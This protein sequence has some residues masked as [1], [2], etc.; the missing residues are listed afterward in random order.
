M[1]PVAHA[2]SM[3]VC[4][5]ALLAVPP[6]AALAQAPAGQQAQ[7][8]R[9]NYN[10]PAGPLVPALR[11][12]ASAANLPLT[13][14]AD[15]TEGKRTAG[16]RGQFTQQEALAALLGGTGLQAVR[17]D[18]GGYVLRSQPAPA[19]P[20]PAADARTLPTVRVTAEAERETATGPLLGYAARIS[21][22]AT[23]T[24]TPLIEVPQSI[25]VIGRAEM[26][27]RGAQD[28]MDAVRYTPGV[29]TSTYGP[30]NRSWEYILLRG[31]EAGVTGIYRDGLGQPGFLPTYYLT[32]PY[33]L[34][35]VEVLRGPASMVFGKADAGG[36][37]NRVSKEPGE[38][39][40]EIEVQY[41][42]FQRKQLAFDLGDKIGG[43]TDLSYR[44]IGV[45]L[46]GNDQDRYPDGRKLNHTRSYIAPSVRWQPNASTSLTVFGEYLR[47]NTAEDPYYFA[48]NY[49]QYPI[50][51]G[52]HSFGQLKQT[53]SAVGYRF[54]TALNDSWTLRQTSATARSPWTGASSGSTRSAKTSTRSPASPGPGTTP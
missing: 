29:T 41:G 35:R 18:N 51:M 11:S 9:Q 28:V 1:R 8:A 13:F 47:N 45:G 25:S 22:T 24:D 3:A 42:S 23:K 32:E 7:A 34:E 40:R 50:K 49:V 15:Q 5:L 36:I 53:S 54:E 2:V 21:A 33:A 39:V 10:V 30:D 16:V 20:A 14:V 38:R 44:L 43:N 37:V 48:Q 19:E 27:A 26:D 4:G 6:G 52:D 12:F 46:D 31:F 17:L